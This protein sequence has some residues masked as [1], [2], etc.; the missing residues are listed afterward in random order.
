MQF[1]F[2]GERV[3]TVVKDGETWFVA[4][5]VCAVLGHNDTTSAVSRFDDDE[6]GMANVRTL[7]EDQQMN[8]ISDCGIYALVLTSRKPQAKAFRR[9]VFHEVLPSI[10]RTGAYRTDNSAQQTIN[11]AASTFTIPGPGRYVVMALPNGEMN[12]H[13]TEYA[14][15]VPEMTALG[16]RIIGCACITT[17]SFWEK[18]QELQAIGYDPTDGFAMKERA[19]PSFGLPPALWHRPRP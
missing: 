2:K 4:A 8:V 10:R 12:I 17:A 1:S 5:D 9:W 19:I 7:G 15:V 18:V 3:R 16:C 11:S 6:R 13:H 14:T